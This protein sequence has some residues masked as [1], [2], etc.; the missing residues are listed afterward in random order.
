VYAS[1]CVTPGGGSRQALW[2]FQD[3]VEIKISGKETGG[4]Y[5]LLEDWPAPTYAPLL[6]VHRAEDEVVTILDGTFAFATEQGETEVSAGDMVRI[7]KGTAHAFRNLGE[8]PGRRLVL[9]VPA[10]PDRLWEEVGTP[11]LD[12]S[13]PPP[14]PTDLSAFLA[15]AQRHGLEIV[16]AP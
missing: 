8:T 2:V 3:L 13:N 7:P 1:H 16:G 9:F 10:G 5:C 11:A 6:H 14:N 15:A 4:A 12:R